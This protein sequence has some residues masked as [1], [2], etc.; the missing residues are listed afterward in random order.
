MKS[1]KHKWIHVVRRGKCVNEEC[2]KIHNW[3]FHRCRKCK[4]ETAGIKVED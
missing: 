4:I 3:L 1:C 2:K